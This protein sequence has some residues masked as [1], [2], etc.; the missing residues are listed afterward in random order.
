MNVGLSSERFSLLRYVS[1][2]LHIKLFSFSLFACIEAGGCIARAA[3]FIMNVAFPG[4]PP[5][6]NR[7]IMIQNGPTE[8]GVTSAFLLTPLRRSQ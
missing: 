4:F 5:V 2:H 6:K 3:F 7:A 1:I 8:A